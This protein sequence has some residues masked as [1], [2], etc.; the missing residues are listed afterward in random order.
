MVF[1]L[2][3]QYL[4]IFNDHSDILGSSTNAKLGVE[5]VT[6]NV[7]WVESHLKEVGEWLKVYKYIHKLI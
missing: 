2:N 5:T 1:F 4:K 7:K 3:P 6:N